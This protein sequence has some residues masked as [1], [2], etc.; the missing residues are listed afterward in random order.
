MVD[1]PCNEAG[2]MPGPQEFLCFSAEFRVTGG[3]IWRLVP[4]FRIRSR[5]YLMRPDGGGVVYEDVQSAK[6]IQGAFH[7]FLRVRQDISTFADRFSIASRDPGHDFRRRIAR[8]M[9]A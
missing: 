3:S 5:R 8:D 4:N 6:G 2:N 9:N 1:E 7:H